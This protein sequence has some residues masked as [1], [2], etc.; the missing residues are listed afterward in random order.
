MR[1][2]EYYEYGEMRRDVADSTPLLTLSQRRSG[3]SGAFI[4][5]RCAAA[6]GFSSGRQHVGRDEVGA[7]YEMPWTNRPSN[8]GHLACS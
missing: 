5:R 2:A 3:V 7:Q 6:L 1:S 4:C 8:P